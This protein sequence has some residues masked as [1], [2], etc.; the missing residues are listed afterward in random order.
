SP[1]RSWVCCDSSYCSSNAPI[2]MSWALLPTSFGFDCTSCGV[3]VAR[4]CSSGLS[5][6]SSISSKTNCQPCAAKLLQKYTGQGKSL[7]GTTAPRDS[8]ARSACARW[9]APA[10]FRRAGR[11]GAGVVLVDHVAQVL[12]QRREVRLEAVQAGLRFVLVDAVQV[13]N[14]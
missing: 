7:R 1:R 4:A 6:A 11:R 13:A 12:L 14:A 10:S 5:A 9:Q 2:P 3:G 8:P